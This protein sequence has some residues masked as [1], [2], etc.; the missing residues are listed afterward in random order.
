MDKSEITSPIATILTGSANYNLWVQGIKSFLIGRKLWR[1]VTGEIIKPTKDD[2]ETE[3][4]FTERPED[5]DSKNHQIITWFRN[6]FVPS[7]HIQFANYDSDK[8]IQDFLGNRFKST[9]LAHYYQLWTTL[10]NL[11][12]ESEQSVND[13]LAQIQPIWNQI[14]QAN[15]SADHLHLIQVLMALRPEYE[16]VRASLLHQDPLP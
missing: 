3:T 8:V 6:T 5:S 10:H 12:Q 1:L 2:D 7:I 14:S 13:F 15:I 16:A 11:K 4:K 9:G